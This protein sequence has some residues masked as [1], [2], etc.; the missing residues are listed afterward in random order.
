M[1]VGPEWVALGGGGRAADVECVGAAL[2]YGA[3]MDIC[4]GMVVTCAGPDEADCPARGGG[5][6]LPEVLA[7]VCVGAVGTAPGC[8]AGGPSCWFPWACV[9]R[10]RGG[11]CGLETEPVGAGT[12]AAPGRAA[13]Y[14]GAAPDV[15]A[16]LSVVG[17][18]VYAVCGVTPSALAALMGASLYIGIGGMA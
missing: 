16:P 5:G 4:G 10:L 13:G 18:G 2:G 1:V 12:A 7:W 6:M 17:V 3:G 11:G 8:G 9:V 14:A 15:T